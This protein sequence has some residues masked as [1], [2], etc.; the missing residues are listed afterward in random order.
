MARRVA[1]QL[2]AFVIPYPVHILSENIIYPMVLYHHDV[3]GVH[4]LRHR[5]D[6]LQPHDHDDQKD[7][8][9]VK[10]F[11]QVVQVLQF[12]NPIHPKRN[13]KQLVYHSDLCNRNI[14]R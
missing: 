7:H 6:F 4:V 5:L 8:V 11:L 14:H 3:R 10:R 2:V 12:G 13:D 9:D 1:E